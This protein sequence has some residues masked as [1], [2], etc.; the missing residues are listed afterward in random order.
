MTKKE[1]AKKAARNREIQARMGAI[2]LQMEK[3]KRSEY[4][5]AEEREMAELKAEL[6]DN[7]RE[8]MLSKD[9]AAI[10]ELRENIDRNKQYREYLQG[11]RQKREDNTTTLAPKTTPDGASITESGAI[12]LY[13]EDIIDT[14]ENG[15]GRPFGQ[16]FITGV[17]GDE[18]YPYSINDV[19]MEEVGEIAPINDQDLKFDNIKV[20]SRR[21][22]LSVAVSNKAIDNAA[23]DLV[24][25]VLYKIQKAWAIYF[26]K[27]N[28]SHANWQGNKGAFSQVTPGTITLDN[29]IGAQIDEKFADF[30]ELGFD[31]EGCVVISPKMEAKLKHTF[32]GNGVA[33]HPIIENGLL[34]GHPYVSTKHINYKLNGEQEYVKDTDEYIGIGLFQYLPIQQHGQVRQTVDATSAAVAKVNKTVIVFSTEISITELSQ[35][36]N[37]N[38]SGKPQAFALFKVVNPSA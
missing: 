13:I 30:A 1:L 2:Y 36:V 4:N 7:R 15:L 19:E 9:E 32:E 21:V 23:F 31:E 11:V 20:Q 10:A 24:A 16:S 6:E 3:E 5:E 33:A 18:L 26:A 14:K 34:A 8:I 27:K 12:N 35:K 29:T 28:Y 38:T 17:E 37:G 22:S 25:F